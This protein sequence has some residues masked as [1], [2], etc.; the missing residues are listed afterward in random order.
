MQVNIDKGRATNDLTLALACE[1]EI[2]IL[3]IQESWISTN[4]E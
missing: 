4:L 2:D 3:F 1:K